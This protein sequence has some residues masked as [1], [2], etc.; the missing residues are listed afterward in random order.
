[1]VTLASGYVSRWGEGQTRKHLPASVLEIF[2]PKEYFSNK[3]VE[4]AEKRRRQM[5]PY[6]QA[7]TLHLLI[8]AAAKAGYGGDSGSTVLVAR[9]LTADPPRRWSLL[10]LAASMSNTRASLCATASP[11]SRRR[12]SAPPAPT[13]WCARAETSAPPSGWHGR[14]KPAS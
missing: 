8:S 3:K 12:T 2:P 11:S 1:M 10:P 7:A 5:E 13:V 4:T 6:L 14:H 9:T